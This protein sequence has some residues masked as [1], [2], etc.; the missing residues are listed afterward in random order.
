[1]LLGPVLIPTDLVGPLNMKGAIVA[2][3]VMTYGNHTK[4]NDELYLKIHA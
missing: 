4:P 3:I 1:V 2:M